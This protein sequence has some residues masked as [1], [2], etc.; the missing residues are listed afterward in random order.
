MVGFITLSID[1]VEMVSD[2]ALLPNK[3]DIAASA[4]NASPP[5]SCDDR[6]ESTGGAEEGDGADTGGRCRESR[7]RSGDKEVCREVS[8]SEGRRGC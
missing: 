4:S 1:I 8:L 2:T 5:R 7:E 6:V 3:G